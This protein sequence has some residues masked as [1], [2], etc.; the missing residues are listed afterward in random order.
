[1]VE[2]CREKNLF[3]ST[4]IDDAI[5]EADLVFISVSS[6]FC[7]LILI[8]IIILLCSNVC[9]AGV[10]QFFFYMSFILFEEVM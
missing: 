9:V 1:M 5:R 2:S 6:F 10:F 7:T 3:F 8:I 4:S